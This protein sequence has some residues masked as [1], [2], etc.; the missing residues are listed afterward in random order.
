[1]LK[2]S[3]SCHMSTATA[4]CVSERIVSG[5]TNLCAAPVITV[6][7]AAPCCVRLLASSA[8]LKAAIEPA[9]PRTIVLP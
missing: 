3:G 2:S 4:R 8:A 9:T 6:S 7:T 5:E 1:M